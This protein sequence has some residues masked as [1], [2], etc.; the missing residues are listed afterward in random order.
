MRARENGGGWRNPCRSPLRS[1]HCSHHNEVLISLGKPVLGG[2][3]VSTSLPSWRTVLPRMCWLFAVVFGRGVSFSDPRP[4]RDP[5]HNL[6]SITE[7]IRGD[8]SAFCGGQLTI[9]YLPPE[10]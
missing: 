3:Q 9:L 1:L 5:S 2:S 4:S 6:E 10:V 8:Q 7:L